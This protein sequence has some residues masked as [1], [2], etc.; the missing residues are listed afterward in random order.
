MLAEQG[1][2]V[3]R[4]WHVKGSRLTEAGEAA[5]QTN[6]PAVIIGGG[7]G[8]FGALA[9]F[10]AHSE[11]A[12]GVL[13]LGTGNAFAYDLDIPQDPLEACRVIGQGNIGFI[14]LGRIG[15]R[16]F[17]NHVAAGASTL[18]SRSLSAGSK[19]WLGKLAYLLAAIH[20]FPMIRSFEARL[21]LDDEEVK[22]TCMQ[23]V[24][25]NGRHHAGPFL[26]SPDASRSSGRLLVYWL[27][28]D[29]RGRLLQLIRGLRSGEH[30]E[31]PDV[32][33]RE[34]EH[35]RIETSRPIGVSIDGE[36]GFRTPIELSIDRQ[37]LRVFV[38]P[39]AS[40]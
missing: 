1:V 19:R 13:P 39:P 37:A 23:I 30:I 5:A 36:L 24:A 3:V 22:A 31:M 34:V 11:V 32:E 26:L 40:V 6:T 8:T 2:S 9:P 33:M 28:S 21:I 17:V 16:Y 4:Q 25:G 18:V 38:P 27:A 12:I 14:D 29:E 35:V 20:A 7:D 15:D 10:F